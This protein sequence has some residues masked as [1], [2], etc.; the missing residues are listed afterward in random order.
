M[1][2][3]KINLI[4][5]IF[6]LLIGMISI[7]SLTWLSGCTED[8]PK[9]SPTKSIL[10]IISEQDEFSEFLKY[11]D[12]Y[13]D[14]KA[15]LEQESAMH[16]V[17]V[18]DTAAFTNLYNTPG[19]P[20]DPDDISTALIK[21]VIAYHII[22]GQF[23]QADLTPTGSGPGIPTMYDDVDPCTGI[24]TNEVIKVNGDYTL[25][26]GSTNKNIPVSNVEKATNGAVLKADRV[27]IPFG[28]GERITPQLGTV[29]ANILLGADFSYMAQALTIADCGVTDQTPL[30]N[31]LVSAGPYTIYLVPNPVFEGTATAMGISVDQLISDFTAAQWRN[32]LAN[33]I[34]SGVYQKSDMTDGAELA[35]SLPGAKLIATDVPVSEN[36]PEGKIL[37]TLG[38]TTGL[39][40]T[41]QV[42]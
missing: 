6:L 27:L 25:L 41:Q 10:T 2:N 20:P 15:L 22:E 16:T 35:T 23:M 21:A 17:F 12:R 19:F 18:P 33:H 31:I 38:G 29:L 7:I 9:P 4:R 39:G 11:L 40:G 5:N 26:T 8:P 14:L 37:A 30:Q 1:K 32:I 42:R 36:T 13:P 24:A 3:Q 28:I 34:I